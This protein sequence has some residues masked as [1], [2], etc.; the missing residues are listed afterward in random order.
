MGLLL[1]FGACA[2]DTPLDKPE[3]DEDGKEDAWNY[4][5]APNRFQVEFEYRLADLPR[6]GEAE[7]IPWADDYW[8]Y[9]RDSINYRWRGQQNLSPAELYDVAFNNWTP[10]EG[11][12]DLQ[13]QTG[14]ESEWDAE[15]YNQLGPLANDVHRR[16]G[17]ERATNGRDDDSDGQIDETDDNDGI[18]SWWGICH[19]WA[20]S[21]VMEPEPIRTV[22][23]NGQVFTPSDIKG[24]M[25]IAYDSTRAVML[26]GRCNAKEVERDENGRA[27]DDECQDVN[28]GAFHVVITNMLGRLHRAF[29]ED[30]TYDYQVWNQPIRS[31]RITSLNE[32]LTA[33]QANQALGVTGDTYSFNQDAVSFAEVRMDV[34]YITEASPS[35]QPSL[36][37]IDSYTRT[38]RYHYI[39]ELDRDGNVIGGEWGPSSQSNHPDFLWLP[40]ASGTAFRTLTYQNVRMLLDLSRQEEGGGEEPEGQVFT[41][42]P[43]LAIPDNNTTGVT[44]TINVPVSGNISA[45]HVGV[46]ISHTY[47]GDLSVVLRRN[48]QEVSL[49]RNQGGSSDDLRTSFTVTD[50]NGQNVQ[51]DWEIFVVD[52]ANADTGTLNSWNLNVVMG[53]GGGGEVP[54]TG[55][56]NYTSS[57]SIS[58]PDNNATGVTSVINVPDQGA[59]GSLSVNVEIEH[60]YIGDLIVEL[61]HNGQI[62]RLHNRSGRGT[63]NI[64]AT[65][66]VTEF[67][68]SNINGDWELFVS[69]T[70]GQ[71]TGSIVSWKM[72]AEIAQ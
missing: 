55:T 46:D 18:E 66:Q 9:Y 26:G 28:A 19:A 3:G 16:R 7:Q 5:N 25:M 53:E 2:G 42:E 33:A 71:D 65:Y 39:L 44:N 62:R 47:V 31:Y 35:E 50:F 32:G 40:T 68:G 67:N 11:Y 12:M 63:D 37:N 54:D 61:R 14:S 52:N 49:Q 10:P 4:A 23:H 69:D 45:L 20:P 30:R 6:E 24:L 27:T 41:S 29:D 43:R 56:R 17:N 8:A 70:A 59:I 13:P 57:G 21:A 15:Y 64:E 36:P 1:G 60:T 51:G 38:D 48:G 58:I 34:R 72:T 22:T